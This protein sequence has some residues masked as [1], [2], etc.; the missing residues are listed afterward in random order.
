[1]SRL[2]LF[3]EG[4]L[5]DTVHVY[6]Y[7]REE[8]NALL[9]EM[10]QTRDMSLSWEKINAAKSFD[11]MLNNWGAYNDIIATPEGKKDTGSDT[12]QSEEL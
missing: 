7:K 11:N 1:M 2:E 9:V 12:V 5:I 8:L 4:Q 3:R 10:G 6:R